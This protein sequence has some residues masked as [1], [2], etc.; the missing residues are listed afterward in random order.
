MVNF[1]HICSW[2]GYFYFTSTSYLEGGRLIVFRRILYLEEKFNAGPFSRA[3]PMNAIT[4][5][6]FSP[7]SR[8]PG[9]HVI[10]KLIFVALNIQLAMSARTHK[11]MR[12]SLVRPGFPEDKWSFSRKQA[13]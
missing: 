2:M 11:K 12:L 5:K 13:R 1:V 9:C 3:G 7:V 10:T 8:D 6:I 4:W